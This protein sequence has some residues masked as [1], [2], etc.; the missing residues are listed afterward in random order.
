M[1][2]GEDAEITDEALDQTIEIIRNRVDGLGVAEPEIRRQGDAVLI[3]LPGVENQ[4]R[5]LE[6]VGTT[7]ELR[8]RPVLSVT[9]TAGLGEPVLLSDLFPE[10]GIPTGST[11][12]TTSTTTTSTT[13][14]R[15]RRPT[16]PWPPTSTTLPDGNELTEAELRELDDQ[17][18][19]QL[20]LEQAETLGD[21]QSALVQE[22]LEERAQEQI[23]AILAEVTRPED[24]EADQ[25]VLLPEVVDGEVVALYT[26]GPTM[27]TGEALGDGQ[28]L[29]AGDRL[30]AGQPDL[31]GRRRRHRAVQRRRDRLLRRRPIRSAR[32]NRVGPTVSW[33]S[34]S[35]R[36]SFRLPRSTPSTLRP[37]PDPDL[38]HLRPGAADDLALQL[39]YG[40]LPDRAGA[41]ERRLGVGVAGQRCARGPGSSPASSAFSWWP[42]T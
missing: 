23:D 21:D 12:S 38:R 17:Q 10:K 2:E 6:L 15:S 40:A 25:V 35:T 4:A 3:Q 30:V 42:P 32:P 22:I 5:A 29:A 27:L 20:S 18:L 16:R 26:L 31:Q 37:R 19:F 39:R 34:C 1:R 8:F 7:A 9:Q 41:P 24:D 36:S 28:L 33:P 11:T 14:P 13:T